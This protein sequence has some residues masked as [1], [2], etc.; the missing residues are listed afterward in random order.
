LAQ[1]KRTNSKNFLKAISNPNESYFDLKTF[2]EFNIAI[3]K[4][5]YNTVKLGDRNEKDFKSVA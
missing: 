1:S 3:D 5:D 4:L 2:K